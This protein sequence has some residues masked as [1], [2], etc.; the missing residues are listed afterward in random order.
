M[1]HFW[2]NLLI[3]ITDASLLTEKQQRRYS[4]RKGKVSIVMEDGRRTYLTGYPEKY[5]QDIGMTDPRKSER[6]KQPLLKKLI[7]WVGNKA[8]RREW[9]SDSEGFEID[10]K[11]GF[12][13]VYFNYSVTD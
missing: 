10:I 4:T 8:M 1:K 13:I 3:L 2:T 11:T 9:E 5:Y 6:N 12:V 7:Y